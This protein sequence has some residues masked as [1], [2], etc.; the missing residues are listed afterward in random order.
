MVSVE[1]EERGPGSVGFDD[2]VFLLLAPEGEHNIEARLARDVGELGV[3][4]PPGA[5]HAADCFCVARGG[6]LSERGGRGNKEQARSR[7]TN[8]PRKLWHD[9]EHKGHRA[10][11]KES[12]GTPDA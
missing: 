1:V 5:F 10:R 4:G 6:S 12:L 3:V 9:S 11:P 2:V 8:R 7:Y